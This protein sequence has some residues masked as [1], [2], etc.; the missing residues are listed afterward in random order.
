LAPDLLYGLRSSEGE[1]YGGFWVRHRLLIIE[2]DDAQLE[3][4]SNFLRKDGYDV[5]GAPSGASGLNLVTRKPKAYSIVLVDYDMPGIN[6][7]ETTKALLKINPNL[8]IITLTGF[9]ELRVAI[10]TNRVG[11]NEFIKK[12]DAITELLPAVRRLCQRFEQNNLAVSYQKNP[13]GNATVINSIGMM[14]QSPQLAKISEEVVLVR[15]RNGSVVIL[16]ESGTGK[17]LIAKALHHQRS[18]QFKTVHCGL[19]S[20]NVDMIKSEL[21]GHVKGAFTGADKDRTG[22]FELAAGGTVFLDEVH[23]L[24]MEAQIGLLRAVQERIIVRM[25]SHTEIRINC[26]IIAA[27]HPNLPDLVE[28]KEFKP[29]LFHRLS[30]TIIEVPD[31]RQRPSDIAPLVEFFCAQYSKEYGAERVFLASTLSALE[32]YSWPGNVNELRNVVEHT[33]NATR[34]ERIGVADLLPFLKIRQRFSNRNTEVAPIGFIDAKK[35][36]KQ[37]FVEVLENSESLRETGRKLGVSVQTVLR[38]IKKYDLNWREI[39]DRYSR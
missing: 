28:R 34:K 30:G 39:L 4:F 26:R 1:D 13:N 7:A 29:D 38:R 33:L 23:T 8:L 18:G 9:E 20:R 31:L 10:E 35:L 11:S 3:S 15:E 27:A 21:F 25:G 24:P 32:A 6:G 22:V 36:E 19:L 37:R 14:G 5:D 17:E 16:G 12:S 2:N